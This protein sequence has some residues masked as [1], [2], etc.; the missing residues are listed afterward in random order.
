MLSVLAVVYTSAIV[1]SLTPFFVWIQDHPY[2][3][4]FVFFVVDAL[5][6]PLLL[7][8][9]IIILIGGFVFK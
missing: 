3:G 1:R 9:V 4:Y 7:P 8:N 2:Q 6:V 5:S